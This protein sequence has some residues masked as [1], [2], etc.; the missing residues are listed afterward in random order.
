M[1]YHRMTDH[2]ESPK[3]S[4][5]EHVSIQVQQNG[6]AHPPMLNDLALNMPPISNSPFTCPVCYEEQP[7]DQASPALSCSHIFCTT[8]MSDYLQ[9][10]IDDNKIIDI[11]CP[12]E[13]CGCLIPEETMKKILDQNAFEKYKAHKEA[14]LLARNP[15]VHYCPN[16]HCSKP[17]IANEKEPFTTCSCGTIICHKCWEQ[18]HEGKPCNPT[19]SQQLKQFMEEHDIRYCIICKTPAERSGGCPI[20][21]CPVCDYHWCWK[22]GRHYEIGHEFLCSKTWSPIHPDQDHKGF[23]GKIALYG[24]KFLG[25]LAHVFMWLVMP[26]VALLFW[27][28]M[29]VFKEKVSIKRPLQFL[30]Y[31]LLNFLLAIVASPCM[32]VTIIVGIIWQFCKYQLPWIFYCFTCKCCK[33]KDLYRWKNKQAAEKNGFEYQ[34]KHDFPHALAL[35]N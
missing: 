29:T 16:A 30:G 19:V 32:I 23:C 22:C 28:L 27:P 2:I 8:C 34:T 20:M 21:V 12:F 26:F 31:L 33:E 35:S 14:K 7:S 11:K 10:K 13:G 18:Q 25:I 24:T 5:P 6:E 9:A 4:Q 1:N 15:N 17:F 3:N